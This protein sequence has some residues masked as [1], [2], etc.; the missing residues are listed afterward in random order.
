MQR[1][2]GS[3]RPWRTGGGLGRVAR[4]KGGR[5]IIHSVV[6]RPHG[7]STT[8]R[9][10]VAHQTPGGKSVP[11]GIV[12]PRDCGELLEYQSG[13]LARWQ[14]PLCGLDTTTIDS[15][16]RRGR[17]QTL[18][19]GVYAAFTGVP[20]R[21]SVL[22]AAVRRCGPSAVLSHQSAAELDGLLDRP[23]AVTHIT[24]G[25]RTEL[26]MSSKEHD[27]YLPR[28][29]VHRLARVEA[30]RHPALMPPRIR[31]AETTLD[32]TQTAADFDAA[33]AWLSHSC[34]RRLTTS[35][36]LLEAMAARPR[37][38][39]RAEL[40]G[41]LDDVGA[42]VHS[43]LEFR[44]VR[45]VERPHKL[46]TAVRQARIATEQRPRYLDNLYAEFGVAVEL[47]G[48]AAHPAETR[49]QD[50]R[51]GNSLTRLGLV[52]LHYTWADV[53]GRPCQTAREIAELLRERGWPGRASLCPTCRSSRP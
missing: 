4:H 22:W 24:V 48:G 44:Y 39:W 42:G 26:T 23:A 41:A 6:I 2:A 50:L 1:P 34:G 27:G 10:P 18:Y 5:G 53:T 31:I 49:W 47:D 46:P 51:R 20:R 21:E 13:V 8:L 38:R 29:V 7:W 32:L 52:I 11:M 35:A 25:P 37:M 3:V 14:A 36:Q 12:I 40:A 16:L 43:I 9:T 19:R 28:I 45:Q 33:V 30:A 15:M 17:W